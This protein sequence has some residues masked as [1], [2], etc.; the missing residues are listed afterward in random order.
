MSDEKKREERTGP[1]AYQKRLLDK[2]R[3][4]MSESF[5]TVGARFKKEYE[6]KKTAGTLLDSD[7]GIYYQDGDDCLPWADG[8]AGP[9]SA[10][11]ARKAER[12][13]AGTPLDSDKDVDK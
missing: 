1:S 6:E 12:K 9:L 7:K 10:Y 5:A 4:Q 2:S 8:F 3:E 13:A 11:E